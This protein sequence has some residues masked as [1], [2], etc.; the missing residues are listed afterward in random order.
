MARHPNRK[1]LT[2]W[3]NGE[4]H[5][6]EHDEHLDSCTKCASRI[7][8]LNVDNVNNVEAISAEFR[9]ALLAVLQPPEDLH[10][11]ISN[12]IAERLQT[13]SDTRLF[14]SLLSVPVE[15]ARI[16]TDTDPS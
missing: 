3:L 14:G 16:V 8:E 1:Q 10:E 7:E 2:S 13:Q 15:T 9:P 12:R 4:V 5:H 11:R 6:D